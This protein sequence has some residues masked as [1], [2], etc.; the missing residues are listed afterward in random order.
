IVT[1]AITAGFQAT[2]P[3]AAN[4]E[5]RPEEPDEIRL[6]IDRDGKYYLDVGQGPRQ[7]PDAD[8]AGRLVGLYA[9]RTKDKVLFLKADEGIDYGRVEQAIELARKAGVRV[10]GAIADQKPVLNPE[11]N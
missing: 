7:V 5:K 11:K 10:I 8:L 9:G 4:A 2:V 3:R 6:G 1:P